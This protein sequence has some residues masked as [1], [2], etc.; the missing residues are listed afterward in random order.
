MSRTEPDRW[1]EYLNSFD[2]LPQYT[3]LSERTLRNLAKEPGFPTVRVGRR[4]LVPRATF[5]T[6][7]LARSAPRAEPAS[8]LTRIRD[9]RPA[10]RDRA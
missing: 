3:G 6:W 7:M 2:T 8:L 5:D 1:P 9:S 10:R 4:V